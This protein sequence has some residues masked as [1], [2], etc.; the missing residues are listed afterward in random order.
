LLQELTFQ[1]STTKIPSP[2]QQISGKTLSALLLA[3]LGLAALGLDWQAARLATPLSLA[4]PLVASAIVTGGVGYW[5][6]P[7]L[8]RLKIVQ[9]VREDGPQSHLKKS[10]TP[11]MGGLFLIPTALL[12]ASLWVGIAQQ[13][14][15]V[16]VLAVVA[17][18][19]AY[20]FVGWLDDW[21]V[22]RDKN[23]KGLSAK[24]RLGLEIGCAI[25]FC[26]WMGWSQPGITTLQ[27]PLGLALP[28]GFLFWF[29]AVF[30]PTAQSN[31]INLTDGLDGL[32]AGTTAIAFLGLGALIAPTW[33]GLM[34]LCACLSGGCLGFLLHNHNP[35]RVMMGDTGSLALG[36]ALAGI[37]LVSN[38]LW[39]LLLLSLI[40]LVESL[41]V[42][43]HVGYYKATKGPDGVGKR[44]FK[45]SPLHN[46]LE[47]SGWAETQ[48]VGSFYLIQMLLCCLVLVVSYWL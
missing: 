37:G 21:Q 48:V 3:G 34:V 33:P 13:R 16:E 40:F 19:L 7:L 47:L 17:L 22:V 38:S 2:P 32:A 27:F 10:G 24:L 30:V 45:M 4:L 41:S 8:R 5:V 14:W 43:A 44:L 11:I 12:L 29:L 15:P 20:G 6:V 26:L 42:I 9:A 28:L 1:M 35:A 18:T 39:G 46:H 25:L 31:A 36:G 23:N